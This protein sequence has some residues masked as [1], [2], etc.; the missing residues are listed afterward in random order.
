M[1]PG[2]NYFQQYQTRVMGYSEIVYYDQIV[3]STYP[4][5]IPKEPFIGIKVLL[6]DTRASEAPTAYERIKYINS[7][8]ASVLNETGCF[9]RESK[10]SIMPDGFWLVSF[11]VPRSQLDTQINNVINTINRLNQLLGF[12]C[13]G[14]VEVAVSGRC[15]HN[16]VINRIS[17]VTLSDKYN[18]RL[19]RPESRSQFIS[20]NFGCVIPINNYYS[21]IRT[22]WA[23]DPISIQSDGLRDTIEYASFKLSN[24][25]Y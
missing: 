7:G 9:L 16:E 13:I 21:I 17:T 15:N 20:Y 5:A 10:Y 6:R 14:L 1:M 11:P 12:T 2:M 3:M 25:F 4:S 18:N 22:R 8:L 23:I 19:V 24:I